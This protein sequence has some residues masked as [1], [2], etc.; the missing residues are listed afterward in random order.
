MNYKADERN[1]EKGRCVYLIICD[2]LFEAL[3]CSFLPT[4]LI[5]SAACVK[6][7]GLGGRVLWIT[8]TVLEPK[9]STAEWADRWL[10]PTHTHKRSHTCTH[11][12]AC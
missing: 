7:A 5:V 9:T 8:P 1:A 10:N 6:D 3:F 11:S 12:A 2:L 4:C